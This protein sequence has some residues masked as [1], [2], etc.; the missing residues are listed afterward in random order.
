VIGNQLSVHSVAAESSPETRRAEESRGCRLPSELTPPSLLVV[1]AHRAA[2]GT[3]RALGSYFNPLRLI[4]DH[5]LLI[6]LLGILSLCS[7]VLANDNPAILPK[8]HVDFLD[9][10][11]M[12]CHDAETEKGKVNLED[13]SFEISDVRTA[14]KWQHVLNSLNA[15]E[16]PPEDKKQPKPTEKADFLDDLSKT[17]VLAR[18][19]L[20]DSGGAITMRRLNRREYLN[21][22]RTLTGTTVDVEILPTDEGSGRFDTVGS[23][24]FISADQFEEYLK[25]GRVAVDEMFVRRL[26]KER[27]SRIY[28][29]E[30]EKVF[31][32]QVDKFINNKEETYAQFRRWQKI[33]D[34]IAA[35][36]ENQAIVKAIY[37][38]HG[39]QK[40][41]PPEYTLYH[42]A[43]KL[44]G[45]PNHKD[46]GFKEA[47]HPA[48]TYRFI[49]HNKDFALYKHFASLPHRDRGSYLMVGKGYGRVDVG[50]E[51]LEPGQYTLRVRVAAVEGVPAHR[52]FIDIGHP[53]I[54]TGWQYGL[55][56]GPPIAT[57]HV[58]GT[59]EQPQIIEVPIEVGLHTTKT[60]G[61]QE[62]QHNDNLKAAWGTIG[63]YAKKNGYG[64]PPAIWIDWVELE[65]PQETDV[66]ATSS[67]QMNWW[68]EER[69]GL[70]ES[71]R[72]RE[73]LKRFAQRAFRGVSPGED[74]LDGLLGFFKKHRSAGDAFELAIREPLSIILASPG[75]LYFNEPSD[76]ALRRP[77]NDRELAVRLAYFLWS[78]PPD[79]QLMALAKEK[80]LHQPE[81]LREQVTR[82]LLDPRSD[83]FV[84]G[85]LHQWL[86]MERLD[87]FQFDT[88]LYRQFDDATR[89]ASRQEVYESFAH[90]M[91]HPS[92]G[93]I[94]KLLDS[95][96]VV[97]NGLLGSYYGIEGVTGDEFRKVSLPKGSP[98][99]GLLG[100]A[101]I[102]A[103][104]SDGIESSPVERGAWVLRH[105]LHDPPPPAP[106][107]VPQL[108][109][110]KGE[111]LTTREKLLAHQEQPQCASCH[112][113]ID[114]IGFGLENFDP[115]GKWREVEQAVVTKG[116]RKAKSG[117]SHKI[118]P[119]GAF[120]G[121]PAFA[122]YFEMR[123]RVAEREKDFARGF[124]EHLIEYALGRPFGFTDQDLADDI[125]VK[126]KA[127]SYTVS[128]FIHLLVQSEQFRTK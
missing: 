49:L 56:P 114:P 82:L 60:F 95:D 45:A 40:A 110:V 6:T 71:D 5:R 126:A 111:N 93:R 41:Y 34:E 28:R 97:I 99:G 106:A 73:I 89:T 67:P 125:L 20:S 87:F 100:M 2:A 104:G 55:L 62:K 80:K 47:W 12:D 63:Q 30:P 124:T 84:S 128:E 15:G 51:D 65:G 4:T 78:A 72:A 68:L 11:C 33:V 19:A 88:T 1:H 74:Y 121:G 113:K 98:R 13:L 102:H 25:L 32:P 43:H 117:A 50:A 27:N 115:T 76:E 44:R 8:K 109:A 69:A 42:H 81:A 85:F 103:M 26:S 10:Y 21:T 83:E 9:N 108:S 29:V 35:A 120:H 46:F 101:A 116:K 31:N 79:E 53:Q 48:T 105:I 54:V 122:D 123:D 112:R 61:V 59:L 91:R 22:I 86:N 38:E 94:G 66:A 107:N 39:K 14:E 119:S 37:K 92:A 118:D 23:S 90:L 24:Q 16:M 3:L 70:K 58:T 18:K 64:I 77:L 75:F 52:R 7:T 127:K 36:P 96:Y 17:M 57:R